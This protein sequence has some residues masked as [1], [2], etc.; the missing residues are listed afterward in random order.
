MSLQKRGVYPPELI[1]PGEL[2]IREMAARD[3]NIVETVLR[4]ERV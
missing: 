1:V 2:Y 3:V 4:G